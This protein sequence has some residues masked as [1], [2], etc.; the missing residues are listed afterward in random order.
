ML[1]HVLVK[2]FD[3]QDVIFLRNEVMNQNS[4][5]SFQPNVYTVWQN[6]MHIWATAENKTSVRL[7]YIWHEQDKKINIVIW[8]ICKWCIHVFT[9]Q[10]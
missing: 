4:G 7:K 8:P 6:V 10:N 3:R 9:T 5:P 2:A 1:K